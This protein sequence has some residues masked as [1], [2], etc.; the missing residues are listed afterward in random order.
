MKYILNNRMTTSN[1]EQNQLQ[2]PSFLFQM[3]H[4]S[5]KCLQLHPIAFINLQLASSAQKGL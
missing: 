1:G 4:L 3:P 5:S 2:D